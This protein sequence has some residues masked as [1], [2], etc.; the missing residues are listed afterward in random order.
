M[1]P[2]KLSLFGSRVA[3]LGAGTGC[4]APLQAERALV[5]AGARVAVPG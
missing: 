2:S 1:A 3:Q 5:A 4:L